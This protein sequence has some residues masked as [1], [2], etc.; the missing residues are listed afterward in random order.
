MIRP[1]KRSA[2]KELRVRGLILL[3]I[4]CV[5][6]VFAVSCG[7]N[8]DSEA[9]DST[10]AAATDGTPSANGKLKVVT[11]VSPITSIA[12]NIGGTMIE[13][14][15]IIPEGVNSH[16]FEPAPSVASLLA[17]AGLIVMN[18]LSL[19]EPTL[20]MAEA[21][22][23]DEAVLL[24]LGDNTISEEEWKFDFSFPESE[25]NPNPHLWPHPLHA[26][27]YGE[28]IHEQLVALDSANQAY[29]DTNLAAF[30]TQIQD[31][32]ARTTSAT[33]TVPTENRK[34]LTY[35]DSWAYWA[36]PYAFEVIGAIQPADFAEPS[37]QE[38][39]GL[40]DQVNELGVP[41]IFGSEVFPSD[42]LEQIAAE[43]GAE[44]VDDLRDDDLPGAP[45]DP[46]H[47]Y[48]GLMAENMR[49]MLPALGGNVDAF[50]DFDP[51]QV[52]EGES[53]AVYPQ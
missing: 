4:V 34:L 37:A 40:I 18:G 11:T 10:P 28:L 33:Q 2:S 20:E 30:T 44:Y 50:A 1:G 38:V 14:E 16:T 7:E 45:G 23:K 36:P 21:N 13:L 42:V 6:T 32:D 8:D 52:F 25:G 26:L 47:T 53:G 3:V 51:S 43:T 49:I 27:A 41:A 29:Y 24:L 5:L 19:E 17:D 12:E 48:A 39:A 46:N 22:K 15:G 31:L 9:G 35:H